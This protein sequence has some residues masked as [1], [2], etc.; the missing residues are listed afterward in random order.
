[1]T[2]YI[3]AFPEVV[4][5]TV[6]EFLQLTQEEPECVVIDVRT[7]YETNVSKIPG[8]ITKVEFENLNVGSNVPCVVYCTIGWRSGKFAQELLRKGYER[9][10]NLKGSILSWT[11]HPDCQLVDKYGSK[12]DQVHVYGSP[13]DLASTRFKTTWFGKDMCFII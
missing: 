8:A 5:I 2:G 6:E 3:S 1:M 13:W 10:Y 11:H 12:T 4:N 9:V 7:S